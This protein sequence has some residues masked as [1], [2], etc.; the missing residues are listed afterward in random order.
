[1]IVCVCATH[2]DDSE[3]II[4][5]L[6]LLG[7]SFIAHINRKDLP[8]KRKHIP[9]LGRAFRDS[10]GLALA[11]LIDATLSRVETGEKR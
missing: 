5:P 8:K 7:Y 2:D 4:Q 9:V 6:E 3:V 11:G 1:M 10:Q